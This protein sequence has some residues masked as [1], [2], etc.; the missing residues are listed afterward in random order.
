MSNEMGSDRHHIYWPDEAIPGLRAYVDVHNCYIPGTW[1][2]RSCKDTGGMD[3][4]HT[5]CAI[6]A[7]VLRAGGGD[8]NDAYAILRFWRDIQIASTRVF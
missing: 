8:G 2:V 6:C 3:T 1:F 4:A 7:N 5:P